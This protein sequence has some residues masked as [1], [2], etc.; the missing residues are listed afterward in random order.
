MSQLQR[1]IVRSTLPVTGLERPVD[2]NDRA[3][4]V[5]DKSRPAEP[6]EL[7]VILER[8]NAARQQR[9]YCRLIADPGA[10]DE[11]SFLGSGHHGLQQPRP[12]HRFHQI[13]PAA[14]RQVLIQI[15]NPAQMLRDEQLAAQPR[16][17][18][19]DPLVR[20]LVGT[21]LVLDHI[22]ACGVAD[23][24][25]ATEANAGERSAGVYIGHPGQPQ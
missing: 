23:A 15:R 25:Q 4:S 21:E 3:D 16:K 2:I 8:D 7:L 1:Q 9:Q 13:A 17:G 14:E 24:H 18:T 6:G 22:D 5:I 10:H 20:H 19:D 12:N 11:R